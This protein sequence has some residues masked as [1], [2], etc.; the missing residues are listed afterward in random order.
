MYVI[1]HG[2][3][4]ACSLCWIF[5]SSSSSFEMCFLVEPRTQCTL[6][7]FL[8][9]WSS[10]V[11][12]TETFMIGSG[13]IPRMLS[14]SQTWASLVLDTYMRMESSC[15]KMSGLIQKS[16]DMVVEFLFASYA[17]PVAPITS[18]S[19][20]VGDNA[21][22]TSC[23]LSFFSVLAKHLAS[24]H[25]RFLSTTASHQSLVYLSTKTGS[26]LFQDRCT[27]WWKLGVGPAVAFFWFLSLIL[28]CMFKCSNQGIL[29]GTLTISAVDIRL[30][31]RCSLCNSSNCSTLNTSLFIK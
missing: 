13:I 17:W 28:W 19:G 15:I 5:D 8:S 4:S 27:F 12:L 2:E 16:K 22:H 1:L 7:W 3:F 23:G 30:Y 11:F 9:R 26:A 6:D 25:N 21:Q 18:T 20:N 29:E 31:K 14:L 10:F 24:M